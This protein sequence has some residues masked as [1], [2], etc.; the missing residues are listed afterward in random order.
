MNLSSLLLYI[1]VLSALYASCPSVFGQ[2][3]DYIA[4][5]AGSIVV[6]GKLDESEWSTSPKS[7][8]FVDLVTGE[9]GWYD[10]RASILWDDQILYIGFWLEEPDVS[11]FLLNRDDKIYKD[12]DVEVFIDGGDSYYEL[13]IN[14][15]GII[16]EVC[17][18]PHPLDH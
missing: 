17:A 13:E 7:T 2:D 3:F 12:N 16:Y 18:S 14:A 6:D 9:P 1:M 4:Y 10:S 11:A 15:F 8:S 5:R